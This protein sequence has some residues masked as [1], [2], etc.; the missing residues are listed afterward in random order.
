MTVIVYKKGIIGADSAVTYG[1]AIVTRDAQK[2]ARSPTGVLGGA[3]GGASFLREWVSWIE[4][5]AFG[6]LKVPKDS[7]AMLIREGGI[8]EV[9][10][11]DGHSVHG[12]DF[13]AIGSGREIAL[14]AL[15][16]G[17]TVKQAVEAAV[18]FNIYCGGKAV[19][20]KR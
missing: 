5:G 17:A 11:E 2:I 4:H 3:S 20:L 15:Y 18:K 8:I 10:D 13:Y 16:M 19:T 9:H 14:G 7:T 1:D 12:K 6:E